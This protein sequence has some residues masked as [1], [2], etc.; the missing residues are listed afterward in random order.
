[1]TISQK[2]HNIVT[3]IQ[4]ILFSLRLNLCHT[5][6]NANSNVITKKAHNCFPIMAANGLDS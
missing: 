3:H 1:M 6:K 2:P 4:A 5:T